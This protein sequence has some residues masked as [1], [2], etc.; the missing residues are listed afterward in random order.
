M[1]DTGIR[2]GNA[3]SRV[4][5]GPDLA[6][7]QSAARRRLVPEGAAVFRQKP[8][9]HLISFGCFQAFRFRILPLLLLTQK[10]AD[11]FFQP[12]APRFVP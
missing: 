6:F 11:P 12:F 5:P 1:S 8:C 2:D 9:D 4:G 7:H 10:F 3:D